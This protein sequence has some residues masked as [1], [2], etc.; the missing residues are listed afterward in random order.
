[1]FE[2]S[3]YTKYIEEKINDM[4]LPEGPADLYDP[5]RYFLTIGGKRIR[6]I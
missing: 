1:M 5:L 2:L 3:N 4:E 6:P